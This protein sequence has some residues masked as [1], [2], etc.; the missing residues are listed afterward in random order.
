METFGNFSNKLETP[1]DSPLNRSRD[2]LETRSNSR[3]KFSIVGQKSELKFIL[4]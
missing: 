4:R 3:A 1:K 2:C